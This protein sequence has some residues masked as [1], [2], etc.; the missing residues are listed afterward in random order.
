LAIGLAL[1]QFWGDWVSI[2]IVA[3]IFGLGQFLEGNVLTPRMVG[4]SVGLHPVWLMF[5]LSVF[6]SIFGFVGM[7]VAV[8]VAASIGVLTRF[9]LGQYQN[10]KLYMGFGG[11]IPEDEDQA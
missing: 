2:G 11:Q 1:F 5:A 4:K 3:A 6:G 9:A 8:P 7:L 10:S